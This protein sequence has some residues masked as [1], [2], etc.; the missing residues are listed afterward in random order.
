MINHREDRNQKE[1]IY[2]RLHQENN[3]KLVCGDRKQK[4]KIME[5]SCYVTTKGKKKIR[6]GTAM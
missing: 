5:R 4:K 6:K 2:K 1:I 3:T